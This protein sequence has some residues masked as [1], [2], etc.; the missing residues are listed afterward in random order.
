MNCTTPFQWLTLCDKNRIGKP[1]VFLA[2][3]EFSIFKWLVIIHCCNCCD[4]GRLPLDDRGNTHV[5]MQVNL[6]NRIMCS[7][8]TKSAQPNTMQL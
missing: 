4:G 7:K 3:S 8:F 5:C 2:F 6:F 1:F